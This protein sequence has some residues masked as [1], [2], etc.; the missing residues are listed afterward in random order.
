MSAYYGTAGVSAE[1]DAAFDA[2]ANAVAD[3]AITV[4]NSRTAGGYIPG[5]TGA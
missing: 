1:I 2:F 3:A 5:D 4:A